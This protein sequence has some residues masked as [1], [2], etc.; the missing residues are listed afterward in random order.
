[1]WV[2]RYTK[3]FLWQG[4]ERKL[5]QSTDTFEKVFSF[6]NKGNVFIFANQQLW[7][8][9][10]SSQRKVFHFLYS[11]N[12][13]FIASGTTDGAFWWFQEIKYK[14]ENCYLKTENFKFNADVSNSGKDNMAIGKILIYWTRKKNWSYLRGAYEGIFGKINHSWNHLSAFYKFEKKEDWKYDRYLFV[15]PSEKEWEAQKV[16]IAENERIEFRS[17]FSLNDSNCTE[18]YSKYYFSKVSCPFIKD[19]MSVDGKAYLPYALIQ[20]SE[21]NFVYS[22]LIKLPSNTKPADL[23]SVFNIKWHTYNIV[24]DTSCKDFYNEEYKENYFVYNEKE[25]IVNEGLKK[26]LWADDDNDF[27]FY[28]SRP[29]IYWDN[30]E[31]KY[32]MNKFGLFLFPCFNFR[33]KSMEFSVGKQTKK[34]EIKIDDVRIFYKLLSTSWNGKS[35]LEKNEYVHLPTSK[36]YQ[37]AKYK[38]EKVCFFQT[39]KIEEKTIN[40]WYIGINSQWEKVFSV[41]NLHRAE[42]WKNWSGNYLSYELFS[43]LEGDIFIKK[44]HI[45]L[46]TPTMQGLREITEEWFKMVYYEDCYGNQKPIDQEIRLLGLPTHQDSLLIGFS[47]LLSNCISTIVFTRKWVFKEQLTYFDKPKQYNGELVHLVYQA[48]VS[49]NEQQLSFNEDKTKELGLSVTYMG[50]LWM[51]KITGAIRKRERNKNLPRCSRV[52]IQSSTSFGINNAYWVIKKQ[53][54]LD[55]S[56]TMQMKSSNI[57]MILEASHKLSLLYDTHNQVLTKIKMPT[58]PIVLSH[59]QDY[60]GVVSLSS[61]TSRGKIYPNTHLGLLNKKGKTFL[62]WQLPLDNEFEKGKDLNF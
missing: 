28:F 54:V 49:W 25:E 3:P 15:L 53:H 35:V 9:R 56:S 45:Y 8:E 59:L 16:L 21:N 4:E 1:M 5:H 34:W 24:F 36:Y 42:V 31:F 57:S 30:E 29:K 19:L 40:I 12:W 13:T 7:S 27:S 39:F 43:N 2:Q 20:S 47:N 37:F 38:G 6:E 58:T 18:Y 50:K 11:D 41:Y 51:L 14:W 62:S 48:I 26:F 61:K 32:K 60:F 33:Y 44:D 17:G 10:R 46:K 55:G 22:K 23:I 52:F